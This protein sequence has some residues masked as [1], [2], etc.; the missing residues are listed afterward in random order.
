M[1]N[2]LLELFNALVRAFKKFIQA[3]FPVVK[4]MIIAE[5]KDYAIAVVTDLATTDL[6]ND[7]KRKAA[8]EAIL[9]EGSSRGLLLGE[10][11]AR[12]LTELAY[13]YYKEET[14]RN[15]DYAD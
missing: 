1:F 11:L 5:L 15:K 12:T 8:W 7:E 14:E 2:W 9:A 6:S 13:Q 3:A 10:S 4:Q